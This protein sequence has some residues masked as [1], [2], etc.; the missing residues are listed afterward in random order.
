MSRREWA[1]T[2][3]MIAVIILWWPYV[4]LATF[5]S[6]FGF[7]AHPA[8]RGLLFYGT[9]IPLLVILASRVVRYRA[10]LKEAD[11]VAAQRAQV[12]SDRKLR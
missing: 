6:L 7:A 10:A 4:F 11:D 3:I 9:P 2:L 12:D 1:E 8:Y 5:P